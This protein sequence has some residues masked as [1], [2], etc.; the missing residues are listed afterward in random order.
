M[1]KG[2]VSLSCKENLRDLVLF[3]LEKLISVHKYLT[4]RT[5]EEAKLFFVVCSD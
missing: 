2:L 4:G 3:P 5:E 1:I